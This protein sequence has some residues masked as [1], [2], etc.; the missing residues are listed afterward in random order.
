MDEAADVNAGC[1]LKLS[2]RD[3]LLN[4]KSE[5]EAKKS[6]E[7]LDVKGSRYDLFLF[8]LSLKFV[9]S[10]VAPGTVSPFLFH[11]VQYGAQK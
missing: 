7:I 1:F 10:N 3:V 6:K 9:K 4:E 2:L 11:H 8:T 5:G